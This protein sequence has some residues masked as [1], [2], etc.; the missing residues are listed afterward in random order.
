MITVD[1]PEFWQLIADARAQADDLADGDTIAA[2][3]TA[4][5]AAYPPEVIRQAQQTLRDLL[6]EAYTAPMLAAAEIVNGGT[7]DD[8]F[9]YFRGWLITQGREVF[10]RAVA[11]PDTLVEVDVIQAAAPDG[12]MECEEALG[13]ATEAY[14]VVTGDYIPLDAFTIHYPDID[15]NTASV[16]LPR[17]TELYSE[18]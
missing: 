12:E 8:G 4:L 18:G 13:I 17:L 1:K 15:H 6:A 5:L 7:S 11:N 10:E 2:A 9:E 16:A 3:A 14:R